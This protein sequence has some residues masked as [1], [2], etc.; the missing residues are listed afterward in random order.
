MIEEMIVALIVGG[1][2]YFV[3]RHLFKALN[4]QSGGCGGCGVQ[5]GCKIKFLKKQI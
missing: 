1:A 3:W 5:S 4:P 2:V